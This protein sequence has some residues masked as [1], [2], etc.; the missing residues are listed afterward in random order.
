MLEK[1]KQNFECIL[2]T[3][4]VKG[5]LRPVLPQFKCRM[6]VVSGGESVEQNTEPQITVTVLPVNM[7]GRSFT[8]ILCV[9]NISSSQNNFK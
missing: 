5:P 3:H 4:Q 8:I 7:K 1:Y 2:K 9:L 6:N